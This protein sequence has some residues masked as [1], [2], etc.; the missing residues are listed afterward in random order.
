MKE[1][2]QRCPLFSTTVTIR[3]DSYRLKDKERAGVFSMP[4]CT[5]L[6]VGESERAERSDHR[7]PAKAE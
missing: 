7:P 4:A 3:G 6:D 1:R 2:P 5:L